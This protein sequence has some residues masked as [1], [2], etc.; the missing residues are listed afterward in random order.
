MDQITLDSA[1]LGELNS[2]ETRTLFDTIDNLSML[3]VGRIV[4]LPQ[5]IV[6]GD[7]SSGKSSVLEAISH[8]HF[9]VQEGLCTRFATELVLRPGGR[10][11]VKATVLFADNT[12][13]AHELQIT[14][15][16]Q[17]DIDNIINTAKHQMG[18]SDTGRSFSKDVLRLEIEGPDLYPLTLVDLP[19]IFHTATAKQSDEGKATV[20]NLVRSYM[21]KENSIILAIVSANNL[22]V[23]QAVLQEASEFDPAKKRTLGVIT[24]PD[25][26]HPGSS[27]E[28]EYLQVI[29][30]RETFHNL[31]L[32]WH[33]LRNQADHEKDVG[34]RDEVE[35]QFLNSGAWA[36]IS[37][38]NRGVAALRK[39]L[40]QIL[41][42]HFKQDL[43]TVIDDI[44][45]KLT[46]R[47]R[48]LKQLGH[49]RS[50]PA[51]MRAYLIDIAGS[52][53]RLVRDG[54][55]GHYKDPFFGGLEG[56]QRK[57]RSQLRNFNR[58]IRQVLLVQGANQQIIQ[59]FDHVRR[60]HTIP[61]YLEDFINAHQYNLRT[62]EV[63][64]WTELAAQLERQAADNQGTE[65]PGYANMDLMIQLFQKQSE[66]W[67]YIAEKH[68]GH[69][70]VAAKVFVDQIFEH[71]IG[72]SGK[73]S[74]TDAILSTCVD[75][76][77]DAKDE[78]LAAKVQELLRPFKQGY[79]MPLDIDFQ[80]AMESRI[81]ERTVGQ[82]EWVDNASFS[83]P[84]TSE[85]QSSKE[86]GTD[87]IIDTMQTFYDMAL[88]TFTDNLIN[89]A[90]E[91]CLIRE[92]PSILTP[93]DV[94]RMSD[95][96]LAELAAES[97][98]VR[99]HRAQLQQ[100]ITLLKKG[101]EQCRRYK[102]R[103]AVG[104]CDQCC[105]I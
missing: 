67:R 34:T 77:F 50:T 83:P 79:A 22:L 51:D 21:K 65:F 6:V 55:E 19:G 78:L 73:S 94:N 3:G 31:S 75:S 81:A 70:T 44:Q 89:L 88:R 86:F 47:E 54:I 100:D 16:K 11:R 104:E 57:F 82:A 27:N 39:K 98:E 58:A 102:P 30:G 10:R 15:F 61:D 2:V 29:R 43:P 71:V 49:S 84:R 91:S 69:V 28:Q 37:T 4:N 95:A 93:K 12:K 42:S 23:N 56:T 72:S 25:L 33:V 48:E 68:V 60:Q 35:E 8:V 18:I 14:D 99:Q 36:S 62:P 63:I 85:P 41:L 46:E 7:Q 101:H 45:I 24:K 17:E 52:F 97:D 64:T 32:G 90:I 9:P 40:S 38:A 59:S 5:I 87:R 26:L 96:R 80:E 74:T 13:P 20:M 105:M 103:V 66:P 76:F 92:L 53:Q 1:A